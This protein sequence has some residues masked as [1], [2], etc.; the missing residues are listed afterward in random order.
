[1]V[2]RYGGDEFLIVLPL[3]RRDGALMKAE[4]LREWITQLRVP[5]L[6]RS[7]TISASFGV[8]SAE[9]SGDLDAATLIRRAD[10][11]LYRAKAGGG[12][13]VALWTP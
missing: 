1:M 8:V 10:Q 7:V 11:A 13:Q 6:P 2:G 3:A 9:S 5:A 4:A 12:N